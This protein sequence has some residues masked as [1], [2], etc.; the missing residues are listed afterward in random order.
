MKG[1]FEPKPDGELTEKFWRETI[2]RYWGMV[3]LV[4]KAVGNILQALE[5]EGIADNTIIVYSAE[6]G[7]QMG[8]H[9]IIQKAVYYEQSI[10]VPIPPRVPWPGH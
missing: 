5:D 3:T 4:D 2:A 7:D 10:K 9:S 1:G 6:H 8:E